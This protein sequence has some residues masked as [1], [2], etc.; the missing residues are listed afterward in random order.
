VLRDYIVI[1][2]NRANMEKIPYDV[3][4]CDVTKPEL[5]EIVDRY[6]L[7]KK[8][9]KRESKAT[10]KIASFAMQQSKMKERE[11]TQALMKLPMTVVL[12]GK[13]AMLKTLYGASSDIF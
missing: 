9:E 11:L 4:L 12:D 7:M 8:E 2:Y 10:S 3:T 13:G 1:A 5:K 6:A